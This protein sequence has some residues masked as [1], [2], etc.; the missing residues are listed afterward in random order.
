M[1][2]RLRKHRL[3][4]QYDGEEAQITPQFLL[5]VI[6]QSFTVTYY[7][8]LLKLYCKILHTL[9]KKNKNKTKE[10]QENV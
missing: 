1:E 2:E 5:R 8:W 9:I 4:K 10:K 7:I 3:L 6:S